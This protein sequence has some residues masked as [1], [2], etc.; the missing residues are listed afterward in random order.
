MLPFKHSKKNPRGIWLI[1]TLRAA[2]KH[3]PK[4]DPYIKNG[5][6]YLKP[7][8][9]LSMLQAL[10]LPETLIKALEDSL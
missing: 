3:F 6:V 10:G 4:C 2:H 8:E 9:G 7:K 1:S 5:E